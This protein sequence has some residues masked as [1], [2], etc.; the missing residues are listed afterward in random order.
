MRALFQ[1]PLSHSE[2]RFESRGG[3]WTFVDDRLPEEVLYFLSMPGKEFRAAQLGH[4]CVFSQ[5]LKQEA[6]AFH[7]LRVHW[8]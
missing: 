5:I 8:F 4:G 6:P 2:K 3:S 1:I 7:D